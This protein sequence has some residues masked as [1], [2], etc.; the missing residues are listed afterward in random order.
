MA[1]SLN[2]EWQN[3]MNM[4]NNQDSDRFETLQATAPAIPAFDARTL[5]GKDGIAR[6][7]LDGVPYI[8]RITKAN[9]L[10][11]TK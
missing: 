9:K 8:L 4:L 2:M 11:L 1:I 7:F 6:I 3:K 5:V 10:I